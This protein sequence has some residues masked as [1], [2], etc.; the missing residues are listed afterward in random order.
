[1]TQL[2]YYQTSQPRNKEETAATLHNIFTTA[3]TVGG[4]TRSKAMRTESGIKDVYQDHFT[5]MIFKYVK[6]LRGSVQQKQA[7]V[8]RFVETLPERMVNPVWRIRGMSMCFFNKS[9]YT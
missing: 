2:L 8:D 6:R 7:K 4:R 1:M 9:V 5:E 3:K